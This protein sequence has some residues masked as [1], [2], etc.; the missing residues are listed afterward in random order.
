VTLEILARLLLSPPCLPY[1]LTLWP[2]YSLPQEQSTALRLQADT[3]LADAQEN[4][5]M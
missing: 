1:A 2:P 3:A 4:F 5:R